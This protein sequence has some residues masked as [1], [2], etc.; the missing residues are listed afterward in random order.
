MLLF[1]HCTTRFKSS[2]TTLAISEVQRFVRNITASYR[3]IYIL[4]E[5]FSTLAFTH[6]YLFIYVCH[7]VFGSKYQPKQKFLVGGVHEV[8][9]IVATRKRGGLIVAFQW[10]IYVQEGRVD[11]GF[12]EL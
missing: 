7:S 9:R 2:C 1:I 12:N 6:H 11:Q 10:R 3:H 5:Q 8:E 4:I